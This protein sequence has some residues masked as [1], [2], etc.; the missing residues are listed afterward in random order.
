MK[1]KYPFPIIED[2]ITSLGDKSVFSL[3]DLKNGF[4]QIRVQKDHTKY[5]AF[6]TP[7]EQ[8]EFKRLPFGYCEAPAEFQQRVVNILQPLIREGKVIVYIDDSIIA[9]GTVKANLEILRDVFIILKQYSFEL[10][11]SKCKFLKKEI[12][13]LG[14]IVS[15]NK[16]TISE[17]HTSVIKN[18]PQPGSIREVQQFLGL[19]NFFRK[20]IRNY[21]VKA[22]PLR[23]LLRKAAKFV[24]DKDCVKSFKSLK[25]ELISQSILPL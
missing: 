10:N 15:E 12:E 2:C 4:H 20:F 3:F 8:F 6:A 24:F 18:F 17:R 22:K 7:D 5:F 21:M 16:I 19:T 14:Y 13:Y 1:Q 25:R 9:T 11:L 23:A